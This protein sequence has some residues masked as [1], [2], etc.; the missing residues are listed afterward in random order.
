MRLL[1]SRGCCSASAIV[2]GVIYLERLRD[3]DDSVVLT[4]GNFKRLLLVSVMVAAK[5]LE[6]C[7][8]CNRQVCLRV[9]INA[10]AT[11]SGRIYGNRVYH[12]ESRAGPL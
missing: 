8:P 6:D 9:R 1:C 10:Q 7:C 2:V 11:T 4:A 12:Q 5:F 3:R